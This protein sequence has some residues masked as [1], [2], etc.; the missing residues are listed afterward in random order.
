MSGF[1]LER[2]ALN[3]DDP[4]SPW[5]ELVKLKGYAEGFSYPVILYWL[6]RTA[7]GLLCLVLGFT[8]LINKKFKKHPYRLYALELVFF[9]GYLL[10]VSQLLIEINA[11]PVFNAIVDFFCILVQ[12]DQDNKIVHR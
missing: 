1:L 6:L 9:A 2:R 11:E 5:D 3:S 4:S 7:I 12:V 10:D 8:M